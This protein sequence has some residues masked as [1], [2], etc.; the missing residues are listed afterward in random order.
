[1]SW[2]YDIKKYDSEAPVILQIW[3]MRSIIFCRCF[4]VNG[5]VALARDVSMGQLGLLDV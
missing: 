3:E 5:E 2:I 1:M 4:Q